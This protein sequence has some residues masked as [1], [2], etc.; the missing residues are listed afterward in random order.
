[1]VSTPTPPRRIKDDQ[2]M[3]ITNIQDFDELNYKYDYVI[4]GNDKPT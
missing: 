3:K 1:M 4:L 2:L